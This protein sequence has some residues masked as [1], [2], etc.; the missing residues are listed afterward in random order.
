MLFTGDPLRAVG[1]DFLRDDNTRLHHT[2]EFSHSSLIVRRGQ[3]FQL[4]VTFSRELQD[5]DKV[6]LQL[7]I[8][9]L[10]TTI[11]KTCQECDVFM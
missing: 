6:T 3:E 5:N 7:S 9:K 11:L 10:A 2:N 8:G 1:V 4:K